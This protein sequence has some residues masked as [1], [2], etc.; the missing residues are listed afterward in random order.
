MLQK[1]LIIMLLLLILLP[2]LIVAWMAYHFSVDNIRNERFKMVARV[3]ESRH[4]QLKI[5]LQRQNSRANAFL[6]E[7]LSQCIVADTVDQD[8]ATSFLNNYLH[9]EDANGALLF[10]HGVTDHNVSVGTPAVSMAELGEFQPDQLAGISKSSQNQPRSYYVIAANHNTQWRLLVTYPISLI[11]AIFVSSPD[12]G[13]AGETFLT[14]TEGYFITAARYSSGLGYSH[15]ISA[16]PMQTCLSRKNGE[17]MDTDYRG[18]AIIHGFRYIPEIGGGCIMAHI[19]QSEAFA[20]VKTLENQLIVAITLFILLTVLTV[21]TLAKRIVGPIVRLTHTARLI[22]EGNL[23]IRAEVNGLD[24]ISELTNSFNHMTDAL[25]DAQHN[26]EARVA[27]R[28]QALRTS[29]ERYMLAEGAVNDGIWDWNILTHEYYLSPR[30]NKILGYDDGELPNVE[31]IFFDL[32]HPDD[33]ASASAAFSLHL[34]DNERYAIELR[35]RHKDGSYRWVLDRGK[36][37]RDAEGRPVR[38]VGS[39]TDISERKAEE[40]ELLRYREH[41]EE[42]VAMATTE[43]RAIVQT[44]VT[45]VIT[46][47]S[48]GA[49]RLFN[50][51][52]ERL[53]GW[54]SDEVVGKNVSLLMPE[55]DAGEHDSHIRHFLETNESKILGI[56]REVIALRKD[57]R[58][59]P[60]NLAVGHGVLAEGR[61]LFV[62]FI[63]DITLQ[64]QAEQELRLAKEAAEAATKA[65]ANFLANMSHE[66]RTPMN[67]VIGFAE[68]VLQNKNLPQDTRAHVDTILNS[69]KHLLGVIN[70]ILDFSKIEAGKIDLEA[71]CFNLP[72]AVQESLETVG[73]GAGKK[74]LQIEMKI[75]ADLPQYVIGDPSRL[76]QVILNLV[77]NAVK[78]TESGLIVVLIDKAEGTD[79]LHFAISDTGIGMT[80]EQVDRVFESF[81]QADTTTSRR[82][83]GTGLGTTIS[84]QL[85][86]LMGGRIWV[87]SKLGVGST[88]HFTVRLPETIAQ[89]NCLYQTSQRAT[90]FFSPRSFKI[91]LAEDIEANAKLVILRLEQQG[92]QL[93][94]V[95]N[96]QEAVDAFSKGGYDLILMDL[97]MPVLDGIEAT[98]Q[99][100]ELEINSGNRIPIL[101]L[102][103]SVMQHEREQ[104]RQVGIDAIVGKPINI[105]E[106]LEQMERLSPRGTGIARTTIKIESSPQT[107][108]DFS[109]LLAVTDTDKGL[110]NWR[111]PLVYANALINFTNEH[112][113]DAEQMARLFAESADNIETVRR[114]VHALKGGSGNLA[115]SEIFAL[116]TDLEAC[117]KTGNVQ[118]IV[119]KF[120]DLDAALKN[121]SAAIGQLQIP[122]QI[123]NAPTRPFNAEEIG[124]NLQQLLVLLDEL[125]PEIVEPLLQQLSTCL[126]ESDFNSIHRKIDNFDFD[127][128]KIEVQKLIAQSACAF[129]GDAK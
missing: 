31:S 73:L 116:T 112:V 8:C 107:A 29:E 88:F 44:A 12:L 61:H 58:T 66:I 33:K 106:L 30:W 38:M 65:K 28:T 121:A 56:E 54:T 6:T 55:P 42:L 96:G 10:K 48:T 60:V 82:F 86:E 59:F 22:S 11:Q 119:G 32:I 129:D 126:D 52:A 75:E 15:P 109:P 45:G 34:K 21:R 19:K 97:Q 67:T 110:A 1:K 105:D 74:S 25:A 84:K 102:T 80:D 71:V 14:D 24:E 72:H 50:P 95:K 7:V 63:S 127:A 40:A 36:A 37:L 128:A 53:F 108:I 123:Q 5:V 2:T 85:V 87:E 26:L 81:S 77:G 111:E 23:S 90:E 113:N 47:D 39:I 20:S 118:N 64:K 51:A 16:R 83:G 46:I 115:L 94:W 79:M 117:L 99:I 124:S 98:R 122:K 69:G 104:C 114:I 68:V 9:T 120:A 4:E 100:R 62:G 27:E 70:D 76:R 35:L 92:H 17:I 18:E 3:A 89:E 43:V 78:F 41:L 125:N 93:T 103:A 49:I 13:K 57:G 101:A 91:L